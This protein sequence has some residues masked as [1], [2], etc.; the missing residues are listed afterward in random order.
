MISMKA[1]WRSGKNGYIFTFAINSIE[2]FKEVLDE[3][4]EIKNE[5]L[6]Q[7]VQYILENLG[8]LNLNWK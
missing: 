7:N 4:Q 2:S 8:C 1:V 5:P 6:Y 3:I